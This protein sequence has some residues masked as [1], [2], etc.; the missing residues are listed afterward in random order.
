MSGSF[1]I[2]LADGL[3][4]ISPRF[5]ASQGTNSTGDEVRENVTHILQNSM[6]IYG[7]LFV[8]GFVLYCYFRK[9][10]PRTF[11]VRQWIPEHKTPLAQDQFGYIS[12]IWKVYSFS[13][14][15]LLETIGL[16]ALCFLKVLNMGFRL[17]CFGCV[18]SIVLIPVYA[19]S[20][21]SQ[22]YAY[23]E[24]DPAQDTT[25]RILPGGSRRFA[26]TILA[27]YF[28]FGY[29]MYSIQKDFLW[30]IEKR[31]AWMKR[32]KVRNYTILISNIPEALRS[33]QLLKEHFQ[34]L[35]GQDRGE[36]AP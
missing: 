4:L 23:F 19:T 30:F 20:N 27:A 10:I 6:R 11:A 14:E 25:I 29:T 24:D 13:E 9:R 5:L 31:H 26:A 7:S 18:I 12:W 32:F 34:R 17:S 16:D 1:S 28:F 2:P 21:R 22:D 15:Q 35:C 8:C 33:D 36:K 3:E